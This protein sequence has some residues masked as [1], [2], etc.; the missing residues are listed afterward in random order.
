MTDRQYA[1]AAEA[2]FDMRAEER[3]I[4]MD[5]RPLLTEPPEVVLHAYIAAANELADFFGS[6]IDELTLD[7]LRGRGGRRLRVIKKR[8][9]RRV[10]GRAR[11]RLRNA[12]PSYQGKRR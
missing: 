11:R 12:Q 6:V 4:E 5:T 1:E 8:A 7:A 3:R 9:R 10:R 2:E